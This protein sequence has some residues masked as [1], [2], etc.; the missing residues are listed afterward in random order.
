MAA[1]FT[2]LSSRNSKIDLTQPD[3][4][5]LV[6]SWY[7]KPEEFSASKDGCDVRMGDYRFT[8]D[9]HEYRITAGADE[10]SAD[11]RLEGI[12][13]SWRPESG[14]LLF[15]PNDEHFFGW[16]PFV[17]FGK[18]RATYRIGDEVHEATGRGYHDHNWTNTDHR[19]PHRPLVVGA[20]GG[21]S[22]HVPR[23]AHRGHGEVRLQAVPLVHAGPRRQ[24][25][26]G[27]R[28]QD[29]LHDARSRDQREDREARAGF[30]LLRLSGRRHALRADPHAP[31]DARSLHVG[32]FRQGMARRR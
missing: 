5:R 13:E 1:G 24:G 11:I 23:G 12:T 30:D 16:T 26:R 3:G 19:A 32:R 9:L 31:E 15:G 22:V 10:L 25:D 20:R 4:T 17:P 27:R 6:R 7:A 8:G 2:S 21:R 18:V 29:D 14:I 28:V